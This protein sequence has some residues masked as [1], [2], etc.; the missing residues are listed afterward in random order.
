MKGDVC[1]VDGCKNIIISKHGRACGS[2]RAKKRRYGSYHG[3]FKSKTTEERFFPHIKKTKSCH[4]WTGYIEPGGYGRVR[5]G[6]KPVGAH[7]IS[8][9]IHNKKS[10]PKGLCVLHK[11]D[12]R[13]CVNPEHLFLGTHQ[14]NVI[15]M[16]QKGRQVLNPT[17]GENHCSAK[18][19]EKDV[20]EIR[21]LLATG[22]TVL[23]IS[24]K[25]NVSHIPILKIKNNI[26]WRHVK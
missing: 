11:C 3:E 1:K 7:R 13:H 5:V 21:K 22:Q 16:I 25:Y 19:K 18:L 23:S 20:K 2:C 24:K 8:W 4:L 6:K 9:E 17:F 15:D 12:V 26:T 14:D 10:V